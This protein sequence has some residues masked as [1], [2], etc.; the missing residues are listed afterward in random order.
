MYKTINKYPLCIGDLK[1]FE[2]V[3]QQAKKENE[4]VKNE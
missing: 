1:N 3:L 2:V 4:V